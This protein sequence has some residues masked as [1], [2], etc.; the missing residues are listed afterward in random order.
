MTDHLSLEDWASE[1]VEAFGLPS[2]ATNHVEAVLDV[3]RDAAHALSRPAAPVATFLMGMAAGRDGADAEA[4]VRACRTA[5][6]LA[7]AH[8]SGADAS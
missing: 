5:S 2:D 3:A 6:E 4:V 8:Q 1:L 7:A